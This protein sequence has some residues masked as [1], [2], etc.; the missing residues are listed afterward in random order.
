MPGGLCLVSSANHRDLRYQMKDLQRLIPRDKHDVERAISAREAG[1]PTV[2]PII[3]ELLRWVQD[4][5]WPVALELIPL[6]IPIGK[7]L[8]PAIRHILVSNDPT[9]IYSV[10]TAI[11]DASPGLA[12][13]LREDITH[14]IHIVPSNEDEEVMI[15]AA[16]SVLHTSALE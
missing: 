1:Y 8:A 7:P 14:L 13:E 15:H 2:H 9:W 10:L 5:N 4:T 6:F 11:V 16:K 3:P 12:A